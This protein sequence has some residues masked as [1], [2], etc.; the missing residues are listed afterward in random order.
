MNDEHQALNPAYTGE[1]EDIVQHVPEDAHRVL[2]VGCSVGVLGAGIKAARTQPIEVT[3][4]ELDPVMAEIARER[5]DRVIVGDV[6]QLDVSSQF[7]EGYFDCIVFADVLEHLKDPW[8]TL[9][10]S[11][12]CL[13]PGGTVIACLPNVRHYSTIVSLLLLGRWPYRDRGIHD[14]THLRFFTRKN[15]VALF[16]V[17]GLEIDG[18]SAKYRLIEHPHKLNKYARYL[19]LPGLRDLLTFQY[20]LT[21]TRPDASH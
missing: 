18:V 20:I 7:E 19:A 6:D 9:R 2:D 12:H 3:G 11:T 10:D 1:R 17:A 15:M 16:D 13:R 14:R 5:L 21:A 4:I 8:Q